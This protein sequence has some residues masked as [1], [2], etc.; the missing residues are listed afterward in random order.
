MLCTYTSG[1]ANKTLII[2][3]G[4][5]KAEKNTVSIWGRVRESFASQSP[6]IWIRSGVRPLRSWNAACACPPSDPPILIQSH[7]NKSNYPLL[8]YKISNDKTKQRTFTFHSC[9]GSER[10]CRNCRGWSPFLALMLP[11]PPCLHRQGGTNQVLKTRVLQTE[12]K[13]SQQPVVGV[14]SL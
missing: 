4:I 6:G 9:C 10:N 1:N 5:G 13:W 11:K 3:C 7:K 14:G 8:I 2:A 12:K